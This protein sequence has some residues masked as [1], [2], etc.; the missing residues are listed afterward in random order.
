MIEL[1]S[2]LGYVYKKWY[3]S[4]EFKLYT[5]GK[6]RFFCKSYM[7]NW[8]FYSSS[9]QKSSFLL[10]FACYFSAELASNQQG[11]GGGGVQFRF[12]FKE[13]IE[14]YIYIYSIQSK[15]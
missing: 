14:F 1:G 8:K 5:A 2:C 4:H 7:A 3:I 15:L 12:M 6:L 13:F 11:E 9:I 10:E